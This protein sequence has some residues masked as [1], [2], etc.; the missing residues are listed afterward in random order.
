MGEVE[1]AGQAAAGDA[2]ARDRV[3]EQLFI[4]AQLG[5][6]LQHF[7][8]GGHTRLEAGPRIPQAHQGGP[9]RL[10]ADTYLIVSELQLE[11]GLGTLQAQL[12]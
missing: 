8:L 5:F 3:G 6:G 7:Q 1:E 2:L 11:I 9:H 12:P 4:A 10:L